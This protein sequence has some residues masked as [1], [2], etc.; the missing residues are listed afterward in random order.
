MIKLITNTLA[1]AIKETRLTI[2]AIV[3]AT[4]VGGGWLA[5][6]AD[7]TRRPCCLV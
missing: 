7:R 6:G 4:T 1:P 2:D 5:C 3:L